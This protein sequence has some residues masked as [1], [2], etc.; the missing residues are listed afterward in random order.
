[1]QSRTKYFK[2]VFLF[3]IFGRGCGWSW[4]GGNYNIAAEIFPQTH[5]QFQ[6]H[7]CS[8]I[9]YVFG[10]VQRWGLCVWVKV[11]VKAHIEHLFAY[12]LHY[13]QRHRARPS[14]GDGEEQR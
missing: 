3:F 4:E 5:T 12:E 11:G 10:S 8:Q 9:W 1:M 13:R 6:K 2:Q 14:E 7:L